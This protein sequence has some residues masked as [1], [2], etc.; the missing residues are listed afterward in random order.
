MGNVLP[1]RLTFWSHTHR[2]LFDR[3]K[4]LFNGRAAEENLNIGYSWIFYFSKNT[5]FLHRNIIHMLST[6][7]EKGALGVWVSAFCLRARDDPSLTRRDETAGARAQR[8]RVSLCT[9]ACNFTNTRRYKSVW[10]LFLWYVSGVIRNTYCMWIPI[11]SPN[12]SSWG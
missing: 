6:F 1:Q 8:A 2:G 7:L 10:I 12:N 3:E 5:F 4:G 9:S 11:V